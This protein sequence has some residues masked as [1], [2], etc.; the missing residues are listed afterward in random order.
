MAATCS[1]T[2]YGR[3]TG[4][5]IHAVPLDGSRQ[6][7]KVV[8]TDYA[9]GFGQFSPDGRWIAYQSDRSGRFQVY[10]RPFPSG[11]TDTRISTDG[12]SQPRWNPTGKELFYVADDDRLMAVPV[13]LP[14]DA[15]APESGTPTPLFATNIGSAVSL[16]YPSPIRR[17]PRR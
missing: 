11:G 16:L 7:I 2:P 17:C 15:K 9:E 6:P 12:G 14:L 4:P 1:T 5:D 10:V 8:E 3:T 13:T